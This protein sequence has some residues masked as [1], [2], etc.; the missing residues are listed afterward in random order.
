MTYTKINMQWN[1]HTGWQMWTSTSTGFL[2]HTAQPTFDLNR[3]EL[4]LLLL[5]NSV[6]RPKYGTAT[7]YQ[8]LVLWFYYQN[9]LGSCKGF[10]YQVLVQMYGTRL[11]YHNLV[12]Q[13]G[14]RF[15][16]QIQIPGVPCN[17]T[18]YHT[19]RGKRQIPQQGGWRVAYIWCRYWP[20][21]CFKFS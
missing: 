11:W 8:I 14:T 6:R 19:L 9:V 15:W 17:R 10:C 16:Y 5:R 1:P 12:T 21:A 7:C 2:S 18:W 3:Y 13:S 4:R 20:Q